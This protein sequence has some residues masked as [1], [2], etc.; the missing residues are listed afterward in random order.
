MRSDTNLPV[1]LH[2]LAFLVCLVN[3]LRAASLFNERKTFTLL[4]VMVGYPFILFS[5][6]SRVLAVGVVVS[7]LD[8]WWTVVLLLG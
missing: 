5:V 1:E 2:G 7:F 6:L 4:F 8:P 3:V